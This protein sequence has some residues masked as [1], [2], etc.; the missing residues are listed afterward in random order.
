MPT[1]NYIRFIH[2]KPPYK[3]TRNS[4]CCGIR[5]SDCRNYYASVAA[6]GNNPAAKCTA[7]EPLAAHSIIR[8]QDL[9]AT[10]MPEPSPKLTDSAR[11]AADKPQQLQPTPSENVLADMLA[12]I[13]KIEK[14][15]QMVTEAAG[16]IAEAAAQLAEDKARQKDIAAKPSGLL[17]FRQWWELTEVIICT[18]G[19]LICGTPIFVKEDVLRIVNSDHSYFIPLCKIDFIRSDDGLRGGLSQPVDKAY[20]QQ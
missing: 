20:S 1:N 6:Y 13:S 7:P 4:C 16:R 11:P 10:F 15:A 3:N 19:K 14:P 17:Q 9:P 5:N 2:R 18:G 8:Q 12:I